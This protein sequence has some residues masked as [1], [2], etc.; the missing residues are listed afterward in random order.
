M[1]W[2]TVPGK[3]ST[4]SGGGEFLEEG[5]RTMALCSR[6]FDSGGALW[7]HHL[8]NY[9]VRIKNVNEHLQNAIKNVNKCLNDAIKDVNLKIAILER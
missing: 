3:L 8:K 1:F 2:L 4:S 9:D 6:V 7:G 5:R